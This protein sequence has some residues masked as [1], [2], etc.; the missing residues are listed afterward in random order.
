MR[1]STK[2]K[3]L[4]VSIRLFSAQGLYKTRIEDIVEKA[5]ISR[6][7]FYNYF[8]SKEDIFFCLIDTEIDRIQTNTD[9][10]VEHEADPYLKI[11]IYLLEMILGVR[12]MIRRLNV[13]HDEIESLPPVPKKL[14]ESKVKRSISTIIEI[15]E[16]GTQ[17]GAFAVSNT[18]LTAHVILSAL[19]VY[20][21]PFKLGGVKNE[22]V[23]DSVDKL[24]AVL[25]F[26]FAKKPAAE[27]GRAG[28]K[29]GKAGTG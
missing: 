5:G 2:S 10:A 3:I 23:E 16:Y 12:E 9:K 11:R 22:S 25:F 24:M 28:E 6:A 14:V 13:R 17:T 21:N 20:I 15:L 7:T 1:D 19:D 27:S 29:G 8:H 18:E 26:G 4:D